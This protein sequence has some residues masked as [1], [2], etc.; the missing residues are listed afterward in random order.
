MARKRTAQ[1]EQR[2]LNRKFREW[3]NQYFNGRIQAVVLFGDCRPFM[4]ECEP[5]Y[6]SDP[7]LHKIVVS[8]QYRSSY[9]ISGFTLLHEMCHA[10]VGTECGHGPRWQRAMLRLARKGAFRRYW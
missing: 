1:Q 7:R 4:G 3:N 2:W 6:A 9:T 5:A 8:K 10:Y